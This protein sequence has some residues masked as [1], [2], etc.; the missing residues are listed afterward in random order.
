MKRVYLILSSMVSILLLAAPAVGELVEVLETA[1]TLEA[2]LLDAESQR[3]TAARRGEIEAF[4]ELGRLGGRLDAAIADKTVDVAQLRR[5]EAEVAEL[6]ATALA[7]SK[8][9]AEQ[10]QR[11]YARLDRLEELGAEIERQRHRGLVRTAELDGLWRIEAADADGTFGILKLDSQGTL[12]SGH[13]RM[14]N[15]AQGSVRG[16]LVQGKLEIERIDA[17]RGHDMTLDGHFD[18]AAGELH[19]EWHAKEL[20]GGAPTWGEW[21]ARKLSPE[22]E[23]EAVGGTE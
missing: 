12:V 8:Q 7:R 15:G 2:R 9:V 19:G 22:E 17:V 14:S 16:T 4:E 5:L 3:Y 23:D 18:A 1:F 13:Y 21:T 20:S 6:R 10:R 11:L